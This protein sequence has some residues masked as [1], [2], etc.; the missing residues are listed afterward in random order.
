MLRADE[1]KLL[2]KEQTRIILWP[3]KQVYTEQPEA[4]DQ[5]HIVKSNSLY[6]SDG[7]P[8]E[9]MARIKCSAKRTMPCYAPCTRQSTVTP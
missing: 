7:P 1:S 3:P 6:F 5:I 8:A 9:H 4:S 2:I